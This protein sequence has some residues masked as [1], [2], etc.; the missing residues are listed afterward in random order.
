MFPFFKS[1]I[2]SEIRFFMQRPDSFSYFHRNP[3][4][5]ITSQIWK[6]KLHT[7]IETFLSLYSHALI[8]A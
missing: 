1:L 8:E 3:D 7:E 5:L 2:G 4:M 6:K